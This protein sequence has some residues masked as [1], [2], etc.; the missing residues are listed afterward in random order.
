MGGVVKPTRKFGIYHTHSGRRVLPRLLAV[1]LVMM[2]ATQTVTTTFS[3]EQDAPP[4]PARQ[5]TNVRETMKSRV[6]QIRAGS[7]VEIQLTSHEKLRGR[8]GDVLEGGFVLRTISNNKLTELHVQFEELRSV[9]P[10]SDP[11]SRDEA[12]DKTLRRS[13][14]IMGLVAG[15]VAAGFLVYAAAQH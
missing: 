13:R 3:Q 6:L 7:F 10:L 12:F 5:R 14:L 9:R 4:P 8:L 1:S 15:G 2:V 11:Q